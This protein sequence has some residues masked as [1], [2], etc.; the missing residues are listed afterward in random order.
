M[1]G[2]D[3]SDDAPKRRPGRP[4]RAIKE[5]M[6]A[7]LRDLERGVTHEE[8]LARLA[9]DG[10]RLNHGSFKSV[11]YRYR[12]KVKAGKEP[13]LATSAPPPATAARPDGHPPA[14]PSDAPMGERSADEANEH[15]ALSQQERL[16]RALDPAR[17]SEIAAPYFTSK[18]PLFGQKPKAEQ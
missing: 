17:R 7:I 10:H 8:I 15:P 11:L 9:R 16:A 1:G 13:S 3:N 12:Q 4:T 2:V 18:P 6:P 5:Q 14:T